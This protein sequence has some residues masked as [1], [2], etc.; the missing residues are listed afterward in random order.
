MIPGN[1]YKHENCTDVAIKIIKRPLFI[2]EK[3]GYR[4]KVSW[5]NVVNPNNTFSIDLIETIFI[6]SE[7]YKK[8]M[9]L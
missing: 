9:K 1:L 8:W 2:P 5:I 3:K 6:K 7:D 4:V